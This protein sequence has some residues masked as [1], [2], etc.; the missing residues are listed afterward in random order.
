MEVFQL[1]MSQ[2]VM[3]R[4]FFEKSDI[5]RE[6]FLSLSLA[7]FMF[8]FF[9]GSVFRVQRQMKEKGKNPTFPRQKN[10]RN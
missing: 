8:S 6:I 7:L 2:T 3:Q 1:H 4:F 5:K 10:G 9:W